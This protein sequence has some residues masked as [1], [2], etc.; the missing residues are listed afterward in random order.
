MS[1]PDR[2]ED[3]AAYSDLPAGARP[4]GSV[5]GVRTTGASK[6]SIGTAKPTDHASTPAGNAA[7]GSQQLFD[8]LYRKA[9]LFDLV[10]MADAEPVK[11]VRR[12][13]SV[14]LA[15]RLRDLERS[16]GCTTGWETV[17]TR[18]HA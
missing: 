1:Q 16:T 2:Q 6:P 15:V 5:E 11:Y 12:V 9:S 17:D 8:F 18:L 7:P 10:K 14:V 3:V 13:A 4:S